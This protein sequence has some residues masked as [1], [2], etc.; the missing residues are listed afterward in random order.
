MRCASHFGS[1]RWLTTE[2][3]ITFNG[4]GAASAAAVCTSI[5]TNTTPNAARYGRTSSRINLNKAASSCAPRKPEVERTE[6]DAEESSGESIIGR[7]S[8]SRRGSLTFTFSG[9]AHGY[10]LEPRKEPNF[11]YR[12]LRKIYPAVRLLLPNQVI[13]ADDL[14][15]A[16]VDA[17]VS[18]TGPRSGPVFENRD[19]RAIFPLHTNE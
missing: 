6:R 11:S 14:A 19:I 5:A 12:L 17:V 2:S 7:D 16:M 4:H 9:P 15:R 13:Q 8:G 1:G 10:P 18:G 3:R